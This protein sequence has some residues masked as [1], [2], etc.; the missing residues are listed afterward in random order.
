MTKVENI[1]IL[2]LRGKPVLIDA[3]LARLFGVAT[4]ALNQAV[5]RNQDRFPEDFRF[6]LTAEEK[7]EEVTNCDH[8]RNLK[9]SKT[10]PHAYTEHGALMASNVLNSDEAVRVSVFIVRAFVKQ[11]EALSA[12]ETILRR[13]AEIDKTLLVHD[14]ALRDLYQQLL[15][16]LQA[17]SP[18]KKRRIGFHTKLDL[19]E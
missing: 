15:P 5:R 2:F 9:F 10:P 6:Q 19:P 14:S 16:L 1:P 13:L 4:K 8:L 12:N 11:R 7:S 17:S 18:K 3:D